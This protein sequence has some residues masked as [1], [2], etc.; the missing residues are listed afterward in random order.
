MAAAQGDVDKMTWDVK[1][2]S[3]GR[4]VR[5]SAWLQGSH[6]NGGTHARRCHTHLMASGGGQ[7][8]QTA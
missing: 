2:Q 5:P 1:E 7:E 6:G 4:V 3:G 8:G